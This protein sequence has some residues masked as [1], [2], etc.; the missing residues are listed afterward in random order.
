MPHDA[1]DPAMAQAADYFARLRRGNTTAAE[2]AEVTDWLAQD[3]AHRAALDDV[4]KLWADLD[5]IRADPAI[6]SMREEA[7]RQINRGYLRKVVA[8][9]IA[10]CAL[11]A[12]VVVVVGG[13]AAKWGW[14]TP[15][16]EVAYST[17]LGQIS[18]VKLPDGSEATLDTNS[19]VRYRAD[20]GRRRVELVRGRALFEVTKDPSHPFV[21]TADNKA[22]TALGTEF[23]VYL[24]DR[25]LEVTLFEG[26]V[27]VQRVGAG[28]LPAKADQGVELSPGYKL[29]AA[30]AGW[31]VADARGGPAWA[32]GRSVFDEATVAEIVAELNRYSARKIVIVD[33]V[34]RAKRMSA[35]LRSDDERA[36]L[37]A[38]RVMGL[39]EPRW[40]NGRWELTEE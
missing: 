12:V 37:S 30:D 33:D 9:S 26:K 29:I 11:L 19:A 5:V 4:A 18:K 22:I 2:R 6:L 10:A 8:G 39:A 24:K 34:V 7:T 32:N 23:D 25:A 20:A 17:S 3:P 36:F 14:R 13:V 35:V 38:V 27:K 28:G 31:Q 1:Q 16:V 21:V 15:V 40:R